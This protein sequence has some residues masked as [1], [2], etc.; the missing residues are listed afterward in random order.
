MDA[1]VVNTLSEQQ[2]MSNVSLGQQIVATFIG[3]FFAF[4]FS[5]V[6]FYL[7][8]WLRNKIAN[9]NLIKNLQSELD[10][11]IS[12]LEKY[13]EDFD[14]MLGRIAADNKQVFMIFRFYKLQRLFTLGAFNKG[15]L[16]Q[17]LT[18]DEIAE[19]DA[20]LTYFN[21]ATDANTRNTLDK[22]MK[23]IITKQDAHRFFEY[24]KKQIGKYIK[25]LKSLK[26]KL[27]K[28]SK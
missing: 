5:L 19:L 18:V 12:F 28:K 10:Y 20:M 1:E 4:L 6:L 14:M 21:T 26:E 8:E 9:K 27:R 22:F 16:Y 2:T 11:N 17:Y 13:R 24:D 7:T 23:G 3:A 25:F 15:L